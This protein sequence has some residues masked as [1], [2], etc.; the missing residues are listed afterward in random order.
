[1]EVATEPQGLGWVLFSA[2]MLGLVGFWGILEEIL[3]ISSSKVSTRP[4]R[5]SCSAI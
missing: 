2:V 1:M 5:P 4:T 3:A